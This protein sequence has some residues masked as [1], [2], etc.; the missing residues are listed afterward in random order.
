MINLH[1]RM[2]PPKKQILKPI[3]R[4]LA[5]AKGIINRP[6]YQQV[7]RGTEF[8]QQHPYGARTSIEISQLEKKKHKYHRMLE[9]QS[10]FGLEQHQVVNINTK[11]HQLENRIHQLQSYKQAFVQSGNIDPYPA[12][13]PHSNWMYMV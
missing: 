2:H 4:Q 12:R 11:L 7:L 3:S 10:D 5:A 1:Q 8:V 13:L 9:T 6:R